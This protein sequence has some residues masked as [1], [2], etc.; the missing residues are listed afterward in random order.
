MQPSAAPFALLSGLL[1]GLEARQA[2]QAPPAPASSHAARSC[3][4]GA[5][6]APAACATVATARGPGC[7]AAAG[8][9]H[10]PSHL[11]HPPT[12][13][14]RS[15][16]G[17]SQVD[18]LRHTRQQA[19][20]LSTDAG[21]S[22]HMLARSGRGVQSKGRL[23]AL[24]GTHF[25]L[26]TWRMLQCH[27]P[28]C[29]GQLQQAMSTVPASASVVSVLEQSMQGRGCCRLGKGQALCSIRGDTAGQWQ[30]ACTSAPPHPR[31]PPPAMPKSMPGM[32]PMLKIL[33]PGAPPMP[34][35]PPMPP[36]P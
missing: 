6:A 13:H 3:S 5:T 17:D 31:L 11:T 34:K 22:M 18:M 1:P 9:R 19:V 35:A 2:V 27:A 10:S 28:A 23:H 8:C 24:A 20:P 36:M 15:T 14:C 33:M 4:C 16:C 26:T 21:Q 25:E 7:G 30:G 32:P 29:G 12:R